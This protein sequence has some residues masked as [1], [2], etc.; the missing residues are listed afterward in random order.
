M[1][2]GNFIFEKGQTLGKYVNSSVTITDRT[3]NSFKDEAQ[4]ALFNP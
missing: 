3:F 4:T 2:E 1:N